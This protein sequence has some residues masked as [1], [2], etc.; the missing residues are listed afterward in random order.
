MST[1]NQERKVVLITGCSKGGIDSGLAAE[2]AQNG[3]IVYATARRLEAMSELEALGIH[4]LS[5]DVTRPE[6]MNSAVNTIIETEGRIDILVNNAGLSR[7]APGIDQDLTIARK[8]YDTNVWGLLAMTQIVAPHMMKRRS[9]N[10]VNIGSIAGI[11]PIPWATIYASSKAAV[12][13]MSDVLRLELLPFNVNVTT[14]YPGSIQSNIADNSMEEFVWKEGTLYEPFKERVEKRVHMSQEPGRTSTE[15]F[16]RQVV[17]PLLK[18]S[19]PKEIYAGTHSTL[20]WFLSFMPHW[21]K[22]ML[23]VKK[24]DLLKQ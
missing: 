18:K 20:F 7:T 12:H 14:V 3:C 24:F 17:R 6:T 9:G 1:G 4:A 15:D 13:A 16:C 10:I 21:F 2:F 5:L 19:P 8:I 22:N 23:F 11:C